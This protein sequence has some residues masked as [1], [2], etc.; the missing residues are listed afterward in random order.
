MLIQ[1]ETDN[2]AFISDDDLALDN[3]MLAEQLSRIFRSIVSKVRNGT[4][5]GKELD[6]NGN[7]VCRWEV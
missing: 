7:V 2:D 4:D 5:A 3:Y 6:T 1:V